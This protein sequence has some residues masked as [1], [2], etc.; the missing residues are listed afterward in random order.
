MVVANT[1]ITGRIERT[2]QL[3]DLAIDVTFV[4]LDQLTVNLDAGFEDREV[5][6]A[7]MACPVNIFLDSR[8]S[9][10]APLWNILLP[11]R[12]TGILDRHEAKP[13]VTLPRVSYGDQPQAAKE[14]LTSS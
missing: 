5:P 9:Y 2:G 10:R 4:L 11:D 1:S 6:M 8:T 13:G 7:T 3:S 12:Q 14:S